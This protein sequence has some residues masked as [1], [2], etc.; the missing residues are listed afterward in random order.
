M[1]DTESI[2]LAGL[3]VLAFIWRFTRTRQLYT[4]SLAVRTQGLEPIPFNPR[5]LSTFV[6]QSLL[7]RRSIEPG[8]F[9]IRGI[10]FA[11]IAICLLPFRNYAPCL[12][13]LVVG[14]IGLYVPWCVVH[15]IMLKK[16]TPPDYENSS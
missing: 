11:I 4:T 9:F 7:G 5:D 8:S 12:W 16:N 10:V 14:L 2:T 6:Q 15:G 13:W 1:T 3:I